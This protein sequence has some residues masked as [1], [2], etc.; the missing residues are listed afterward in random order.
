M[1]GD[2]SGETTQQLQAHDGLF[3]THQEIQLHQLYQE[4]AKIHHQTTKSSD[5][6]VHASSSSHDAHV[7]SHAP[8]ALARSSSLSTIGSSAANS[9]LSA[10]DRVK[11]VMAAK[12]KQQ[13]SNPLTKSTVKQAAP[14]KRANPLA[15]LLKP[16]A[17]PATP[18]TIKRPRLHSSTSDPLPSSSS[19]HGPSTV[20]TVT[21]EMRLSNGRGIQ[22]P[23]ESFLRTDEWSSEKDDPLSVTLPAVVFR[24]NN[25]LVVNG[26]IPTHSCRFVLNIATS[27]GTIVCHLNPRKMRGGQI[28]LNS[29]VDQRWGTPQIVHRCPLVFGSAAPCA[30]MLRITITSSGFLLYLDEMFVEEL[31]HRMPLR[32]GDNLLLQVPVKDEYGNPEVV[33]I[34]N[35]W[36]GH[37][38]MTSSHQHPSL[39]HA[40]SAHSM[41]PTAPPSR[42]STSSFG[43]SSTAA[44]A[45][46]RYPSD[47][48]NQF[49]VYVGNLPSDATRGDLARLFADFSYDYIRITPRGFGFVA[50]KNQAD[51]DRA[52]RELDGA[53]LPG[54]T[55]S[56]KI[57]VALSKR[58]A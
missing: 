26:L 19:S 47:G 50:L 58:T 30:F 24:T 25:T 29:F 23:P 17:S 20:N 9:S 10:I 49:D 16:G 52:V 43:S 11:A 1:G 14:N 48:R 18:S 34:H 8:A 40:P 42:T 57:S 41:T 32:E 12:A 36:W 35:V 2:D 45:A 22:L 53:M 21:G 27:D 51:V 4:L 54:F 44:A 39:T 31:K 6:N 38:D 15:D 7:H 37:T 13:S 28:L 5:S 55:V 46:P 3:L 56:L 33:R